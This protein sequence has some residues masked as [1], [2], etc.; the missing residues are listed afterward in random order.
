MGVI[1]FCN[2]LAKQLGI[3]AR[4][5]GVVNTTLLL[6][7]IVMKFLIGSLSD[8]VQQFKIILIIVIS[9]QNIFH[10]LIIVIPRI[11]PT[12]LIAETSSSECAS[13]N[14][15]LDV[16]F[17][18]GGLG[19]EFHENLNG[20]TL[21]C[22]YHFAKPTVNPDGSFELIVDCGNVCDTRTWC[23]SLN[24]LDNQT[25][26]EFC[27][28][29]AR[30]CTVSCLALTQPS[31][32]LSSSFWL[33]A[34]F[35]T[36]GGI[37]F[38]VGAS[39]N[40][41]ATYAIL[42]ERRRDYGKQRL[43]GT[44]GW[45]CIAPIVGLLNERATGDSSYV[46]YS[47][48]FYTLAL[49]SVLDVCGTCFLNVPRSCPSSQ[50][51]KDLSQVF[52]KPEAIFFTFSVFNMGLL[53]GFIW[54]Y[55][56][57][58][59]QDLGASPSLLGACL[60]IQCFGGE[61]P[62]LFF[63]GWIIMRIGYGNAMSLS[64]VGL[65]CRLG[66]YSFGTNVRAMLPVEVTHGLCFGLFYATMTSFANTVAPPGTQATMQGLLGGTFEGLGKPS[67]FHLIQAGLTQVSYPPIEWSKAA[68]PVIST[69]ENCYI[70][71][72]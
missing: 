16:C 2:V 71:R 69:L 43:W 51:L 7:T 57:W 46:D 27:N 54:A 9:V 1:P 50:I 3:P 62:M 21:T 31:A 12:K 53:M 35:R 56:L 32:A 52:L 17:T 39:L 45:G 4:L 26:F 18:N 5:V 23:V 58:Y 10:F 24:S 49:L 48:G 36:V 59:L 67:F 33:Y 63:S 55:G 6:S 25:A 44:I 66:V 70:G 65:A 72:C 15:S 19:S 8:K 40:D 37:G 41:A 68:C 13:T 60:A 11:Q 22:T 42:K 61:V 30:R 14:V 38:S 34:L 29:G 47:P 64:I 28:A 20:C